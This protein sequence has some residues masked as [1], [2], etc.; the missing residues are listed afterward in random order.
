V[1]TE[2]ESS[3]SQVQKIVTVSEVGILQ[4]LSP[5]FSMLACWTF[6]CG[7]GNCSKIWSA[8]G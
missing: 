2:F 6:F 1:T 5:Q 4:D 8:R 3:M 7:V